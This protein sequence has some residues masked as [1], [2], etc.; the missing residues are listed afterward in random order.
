MNAHVQI[1]TGSKSAEITDMTNAGKRGKYCAQTRAYFPGRDDDGGSLLGYLSQP[2]NVARPYAEIVAGIA[3]L[4]CAGLNIEETQIKG[5]HAPRE[6]LKAGKDGIWSASAGTE[7]LYL[8]DLT[9]H[10]NEPRMIT[11]RQT[12]AEAYRRA[13]AVWPRVILAATL[14]EVRNILEGAGCRLHYYCAMD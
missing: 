5:I 1:W 14:L 2:E 10:Y 9:D 8:A 7:G 11:S 3:A 6:T 12:A 13:S 4:N